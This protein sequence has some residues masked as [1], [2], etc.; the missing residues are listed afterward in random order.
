M[1]ISSLLLTAAFVTGA[2]IPLQ[3]AFNAQLGAVTKNP[4]TAA[5]IVFLVGAAL[6]S[7]A[8]ALLRPPLPSVAELVEAPKTMWLGGLIAA[9]YILSVVVITPRLGVG[10]TTVFILAGQIGMALLIDHFGL[11]GNPQHSLN[12]WRLGG[13]LL[14]VSG[15]IAIKTH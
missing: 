6:L 13:A 14:L 1:N 4:Y 10:L 9:A 5:L 3:L 8:V 2:I 11:F 15:I 12:L 7:T